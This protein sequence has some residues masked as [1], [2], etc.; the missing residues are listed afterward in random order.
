MPR[1]SCANRSLTC[2]ST[3]S[4]KPA[5]RL[6]ECKHV[7]AGAA[8]TIQEQLSTLL[9]TDIRPA[10]CHIGQRVLAAIDMAVEQHGCP[11]TI[12]QRAGIHLGTA[13]AS[14][15]ADRTACSVAL[16]A[17]MQPVMTGDTPQR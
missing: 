1:S 9:P 17:P 5:R 7:R 2:A 4:S 11:A 8:A 14:M 15:L 6:P 16:S 3:A 10:H 12:L 13:A